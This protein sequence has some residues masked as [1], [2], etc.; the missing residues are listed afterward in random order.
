MYNIRVLQ[1]EEKDKK[2][3]KNLRDK[4]VFTFFMMNALYV[5]VLVML[6]LHSEEFS[7]KWP[8]G[9]KVCTPYIN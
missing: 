9:G 7:V 5:L 6:H 1:K 4:A 8:L 2:T 3:L